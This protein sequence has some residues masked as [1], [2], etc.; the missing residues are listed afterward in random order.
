MVVDLNP[1]SFFFNVDRTTVRPLG[2][3]LRT[4]RG[5]RRKKLTLIC[6]PGAASSLPSPPSPPSPQRCQRLASHVHPHMTTARDQVPPPHST[7]HTNKSSL[8]D[9]LFHSSY[10]NKP[11]TQKK[12]KKTWT[13]DF[14]KASVTPTLC[15]TFNPVCCQPPLLPSVTSRCDH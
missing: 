1:T 14:S 2:G 11:P 10:L 8:R 7:P 4:W 9:F 3:L 5:S 6:L 13:R 15:L 12:K